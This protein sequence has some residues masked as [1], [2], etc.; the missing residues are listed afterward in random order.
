VTA[1]FSS[2]KVT[3]ADRNLVLTNCGLTKLILLYRRTISIQITP[4]R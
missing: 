2:T 1:K 4:F 3:G